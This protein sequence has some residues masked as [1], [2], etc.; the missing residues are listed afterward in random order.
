MAF[1]VIPDF[2]KAIEVAVFE[3]ETAPKKDWR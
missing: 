1:E 2:W 3:D